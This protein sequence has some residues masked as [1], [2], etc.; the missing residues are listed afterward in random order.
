MNSFSPLATLCGRR[1]DPPGAQVMER[2]RV[3]RVLKNGG[4]EVAWA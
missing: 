2:E 1:I 4:K 3:N